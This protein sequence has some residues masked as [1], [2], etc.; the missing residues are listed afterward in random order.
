MLLSYV[1]VGEEMFLLYDGY[2]GTYACLNFFVDV[3]GY[4]YAPLSRIA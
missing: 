1:N 3:Y 2:I 4:W